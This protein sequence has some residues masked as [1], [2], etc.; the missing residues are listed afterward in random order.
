MPDIEGGD[1]LLVVAYFFQMPWKKYM[2]FNEFMVL[3][4]SSRG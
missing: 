4:K 3:Q 2:G 1:I